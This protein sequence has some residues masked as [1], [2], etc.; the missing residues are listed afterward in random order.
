M[1]QKFYAKCTSAFGMLSVWSHS[2]HTGC[3]HLHRHVRSSASNKTVPPMVFAQLSL[4]V[5]DLHAPRYGES[6][7]QWSLGITVDGPQQ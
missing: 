2:D 3:A 6:E 5:H 4:T 1:M 7:L